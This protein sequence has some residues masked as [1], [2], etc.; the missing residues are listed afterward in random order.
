MT[1]RTLPCPTCGN[2]SP[3]A[4]FLAS[5]LNGNRNPSVTHLYDAAT[6]ARVAAE[7]KADQAAAALRAAEARLAGLQASA[8]AAAARASLEAQDAANAGLP[9][10]VQEQVRS[11]A[12][13]AAEAARAFEAEVDAEG[14]RVF[15]LRAE[16]SDL[17]TYAAQVADATFTAAE[18]EAAY[19]E[20]GVEESDG[21]IYPR[22]PATEEQQATRLLLGAG[23]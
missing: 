13:R 20:L 22:H 23:F 5:W 9:V 10:V 4:R 17:A 19:S 7:A 15:A 18:L 16:A 6:R 12:E 2:P 8:K 11:S 14:V 21:R 3:A 1:S